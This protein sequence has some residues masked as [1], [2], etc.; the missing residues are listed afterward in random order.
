MDSTTYVVVA[1]AVASAANMFQILT[2]CLVQC[3]P[4][5]CQ[6]SV[7]P[8]SCTSPESLGTCMTNKHLT[9]DKNIYTTFIQ[10]PVYL[11]GKAVLKIKK[12]YNVKCTPCFKSL[13]VGC[14]TVK[15]RERLS[16][17]FT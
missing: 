2:P 9:L 10:K 4:I 5:D 8:Q 15:L 3:C 17:Y 6:P 14:S 16:R 11:L 13:F 1:T 7:K 12:R